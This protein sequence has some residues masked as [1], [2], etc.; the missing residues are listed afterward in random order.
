MCLVVGGVKEKVLGAHR[1]GANKVIAPR[2]NRKDVELAVPKEV[3]ARMQFV[4]SRTVRE[5][6]DAAFEGTLP[7]HMLAPAVESRLCKA[8]L[9][10][11]SRQRD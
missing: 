4:F 2:A 11:A 5:T 9:H 3:R 7:W 1:T 8:Q 6:L 10:T